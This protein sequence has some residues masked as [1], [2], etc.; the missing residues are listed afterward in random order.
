MHCPPYFSDRIN[1]QEISLEDNWLVSSNFP[2][3]TTN[4]RDLPLYARE[5]GARVIRR[6]LARI[7]GE[8]LDG[9]ARHRRES[10]P[11]RLFA[12]MVKFLATFHPTLVVIDTLADVLAATKLSALMLGNLSKTS[13]AICSGI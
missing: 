10:V 13:E 8:S 12:D 1:S 11:T 7:S 6:S 5:P 3:G 9:H 4:Y 2:D